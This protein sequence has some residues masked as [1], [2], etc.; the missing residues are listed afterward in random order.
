MF[1]LK[2][3]TAE[4]EFLVWAAALRVSAAAQFTLSTAAV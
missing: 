4:C 2:R 3:N 1:A